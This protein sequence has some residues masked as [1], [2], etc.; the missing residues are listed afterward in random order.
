MTNSL[1]Q[2]PIPGLWKKDSWPYVATTQCLLLCMRRH[3]AA[4]EVGDLH[5]AQNEL[6]TAQKL[7]RAANQFQQFPTTSITVEPVVTTDAFIQKDPETPVLYGTTAPDVPIAGPFWPLEVS[8]YLPR[9]VSKK[10]CLTA[11][12]S[13][14][15][16]TDPPLIR[17]AGKAMSLVIFAILSFFLLGCISLMVQQFDSFSVVMRMA[18]KVLWRMALFSGALFVAGAV[19]SSLKS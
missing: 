13:V 18:T 10:G 15:E 16:P 6:Q 1:I 17:Y 8:N 19:I 3:A 7:L 2:Q 12:T 4:I 9:K 14:I 5:A 11:A